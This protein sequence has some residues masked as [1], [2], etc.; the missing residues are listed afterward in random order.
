MRNVGMGKAANFLLGKNG[1]KLNMNDAW[2]VD[3][4]CA[5][6]EP[7]LSRMSSCV[8]DV[9]DGKVGDCARNFGEGILDSV[10]R[11]GKCLNL[12]RHERRM[13]RSWM[14]E[15]RLSGGRQRVRR[16]H[17]PRTVDWKAP[18]CATRLLRRSFG[19]CCEK[20]ALGK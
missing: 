16:R 1:K 15:D 11:R 9:A 8:R 3:I 12:F 19:E 6:V 5:V 18:H 10:E 4:G 20:S 13:R 17:T 7:Q 14:E 2:D